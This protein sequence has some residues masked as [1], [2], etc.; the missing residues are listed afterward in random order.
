MDEKREI[1]HNMAVYYFN[2]YSKVSKS[3]CNLL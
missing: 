1:G 2:N 3:L